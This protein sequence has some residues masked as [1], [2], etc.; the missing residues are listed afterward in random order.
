[1]LVATAH[2]AALPDLLKNDELSRLAGGVCNV[3]LGDAAAGARRGGAK[4]RQE[5]AGAPVF[6]ILVEL[7]ARAEWRLH[8]SVAA[9]VDQMLAGRP[10]DAQVRRLRAGGRAVGAVEFETPGAAEAA[11]AAGLDGARGGPR[12]G[13]ARQAAGGTGGRPWL[14]LPPGFSG[15]GGAAAGGK[16]PRSVVDRSGH[17]TPPATRARGDE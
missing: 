11:A 6:S 1:V 2:G 10:P 7:R 15:G 16:R 8:L 12:R 9:S 13:G 5:R 14:A 4:T 3:T 17:D